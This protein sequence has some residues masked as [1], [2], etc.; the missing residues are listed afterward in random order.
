MPRC[1]P[2]HRSH[3]HTR[4]RDNAPQPITKANHKY[5]MIPSP[6]WGRSRYELASV[7]H[8]PAVNGVLCIQL[9]SMCDLNQRSATY[10]HSIQIEH[11]IALETAAADL[12][13]RLCRA[14]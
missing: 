8:E 1:Y 12:S 3:A 4:F 5:F 7:P 6:L 14:P 11:V 13:P 9:S 2:I 10:L